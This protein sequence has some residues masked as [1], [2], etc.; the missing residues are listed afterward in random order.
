MLLAGVGSYLLLNTI[1][2]LLYSVVL[3]IVLRA[4]SIVF[5][6]RSIAIL[7]NHEARSMKFDTTRFPRGLPGSFW[8]EHRT[9]VREIAR[10][11]LRLDQYSGSFNNGGKSAAF[12]L[13]STTG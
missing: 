13:T 4:K 7:G 5:F 1:F 10:Q 11:K 12:E 3:P 6:V 9:T 2:H 8:V